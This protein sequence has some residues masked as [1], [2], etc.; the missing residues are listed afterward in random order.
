MLINVWSKI[1]NFPHKEKKN[2]AEKKKHCIFFRK[3]ATTPPPSIF[4]NE[5]KNLS[6]L[7]FLVQIFAQ[8]KSLILIKNYRLSGGVIQFKQST[9]YQRKKTVQ[10]FV[11]L[12]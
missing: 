4:L 12:F 6:C 10:F 3:L 8:F 5:V 2:N 7:A 9:Y 1:L 11:L